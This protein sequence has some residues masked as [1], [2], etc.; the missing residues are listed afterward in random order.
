MTPSGST[1]TGVI[2]LYQGA[3]WIREAVDSVSGQTSPPA[4]LIVVDDG[5]TDGGA[6]L[7]PPTPFPVRVI[8]QGNAGQGAARNTGIA[9]A[10]TPYV[11]LLDQDDLWHPGH[12]AALVGAL[13]PHDDR[14]ALVTSDFDEA[15][16]TGIRIAS[17]IAT[18]GTRFPHTL[19]SALSTSVNTLPS[20]TL[21]RRDH[22][23]DV[24]GFDVRLRGY[25]DDDLLVR[26]LRAGRTH[27]F[28]PEV[29]TTHR[30]HGQNTSH[31]PVFLRSR[32]VYATTLLDQADRDGDPHQRE[33]V[34]RRFR[35][36]TLVDYGDALVA[37]DEERL[38]L[39]TETY[40][41]LLAAAG[42][43]PGRMGALMRRPRLLRALLGASARLP[44]ALRPTWPEGLERPRDTHPT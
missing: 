40:A 19:G 34:L 15:D 33:I 16:E 17:Y 8:R 28:V 12:L 21:Y 35:T 9:A 38:R 18:R 6:D 2:P 43:P 44:R 7:I 11:A 22:V 4:E 25:E 24:G 13:E 36:S 26:L 27:R 20:A 31:S 42:D 32:V 41:A 5:S 39:L 14:L 23:L 3:A 37:H 29:T 30:L 10:R 1:V